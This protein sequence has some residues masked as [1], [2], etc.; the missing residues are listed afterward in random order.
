MPPTP[1][2][3]KV[4]T[5]DLTPDKM[6]RRGQAIDATITHEAFHSTMENFERNYGKQA[7]DKAHVGLLNQYDKSCLSLVGSFIAQRLGYDM[8]SPKFTEEILA[9]ARDILVNPKKREDFKKYAGREADM[10]IKNLKL[11]HQKAYEYAKN[12]KPEDLK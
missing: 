2:K 1:S 11:G 7:A 9:H 8:K 5:K 10:Q 6:K 12:L 3:K 4:E